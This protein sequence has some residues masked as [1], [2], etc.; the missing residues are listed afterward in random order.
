MRPL[1]LALL[2]IAIITAPL[3]AAEPAATFSAPAPPESTVSPQ[4]V[5]EGPEDRLG[6]LERRR[7]GLTLA[8]AA[9]I[10]A[11]LRDQGLIEKSTPRS[12]TATLILGRLQAENPEAWAPRIA[13][14]QQL[15]AAGDQNWDEFFQAA[16]R[17]L[18]AL[19]PLIE[20]LIALFASTTEAILY[21]AAL[22]LCWR[23]RRCDP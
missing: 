19:L 8:N 13:E 17:F 11:D 21:A 6:W 12:L 18:E 9:R 22:G 23:I 1:S 5:P 4:T 10:A 20:L 2:L 16:I 7:L 15:K 3:A 14:A